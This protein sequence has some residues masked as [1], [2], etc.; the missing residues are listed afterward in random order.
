MKFNPPYKLLAYSFIFLLVGG[1][2]GYFIG[3]FQQAKKANAELGQISPI[4]ENNSQYKFIHPLLG[5]NT[6][7]STD[8][9]EIKSLESQVQNFINTQIAEHKINRASVY[10]KNLN[11]GH[12]MAINE[13][14]K[15]TPASLFK[16]PLLIAY[17]K[18]AEQRPE[19]LKNPLTKTDSLDQDDGESIRPAQSIK[20]KQP[21]TVEELL[22][23]MIKYSDNNATQL[24]FDAADK[25][26]FKEIFSDLRISLPS[27]D[28][29]EDFITV[30]DYAFFFRIL[31][32]ATYL[33]R[34]ESEKALNLLSQTTYKDGLV[35][36]VPA[37][38]TVAHKF[39]EY[40]LINNGKV[41]KRQ[42]HDCGIIY[43]LDNPYKLCVM[44]EGQNFEDLKATIAQISKLVYGNT[45]NLK[46]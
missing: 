10:Y 12:W 28:A 9:S 44:T 34:E 37:N 6:P 26:F 19:I 22:E 31:Y 2:C 13:D 30:K 25:N 41:E 21:Y 45:P 16:V 3:K 27:S 42:L 1:F 33:N 11:N 36:G 5:Y 8:L 4:R 46:K 15:Y 29:E 35:A 18:T 17:L 40:S 20:L 43:A 7:E 39:G 32:N 23:F 24:L 14:Q 38:M